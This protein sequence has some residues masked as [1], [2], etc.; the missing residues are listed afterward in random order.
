MAHIEFELTR[1]QRGLRLIGTNHDDFDAVRAIFLG[2]A[3]R[4]NTVPEYFISRF[5]IDRHTNEYLST[6][7]ALQS[8][9]F[10]YCIV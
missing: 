5:F 9:K 6:H 1:T 3:N 10:H 4:I 8:T 2:I 7:F